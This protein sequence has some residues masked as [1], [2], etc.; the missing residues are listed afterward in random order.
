MKPWTTKGRNAQFGSSVFRS[1]QSTPGIV[2]VTPPYLNPALLRVGDQVGGAF[3]SGAY[4]WTGGPVTEGSP[5]YTVNGVTKA[6]NYVLL[7]GDIV[8][9]A[10]V[11]LT[12]SGAPSITVYAEPTDVTDFSYTTSDFEYTVPAGTGDST[13]P[14]ISAPTATANGATAIDGT[15]DTTEGNG[16]LWIIAYDSGHSAPA[17]GAAVKAGNDGSGA[18]L[19]S[20]SQA[21]TA[22]GTQNVALTGVSGAASTYK[23]AYAHED[24]Y[25]N[26]SNVSIISGTITL[27]VAP[28][29]SSPTASTVKCTS[30]SIGVTTD[31]STGTLYGILSTSATA[32]TAAQIKAGQNHTG[33]AATW[34]G[35]QSISST[36]AKSFTPTGLTPGSTLYAH[37]THYN[38]MDSNVASASAV[39]TKIITKIGSFFNNTSAQTQGATYSLDLTTPDTTNG[40]I[41]GSLQQDDIIIFNSGWASTSDDNPS[42]AGITSEV[43]DQYANATQQDTNQSVGYLVC[44]ASPPS[45]VTVTGSNNAANGALAIAVAYRYVDPVTPMDVAAQAGVLTASTVVDAGA[46]TPTSVGAKIV[47]A[48]ANSGDTTPVMSGTPSN[49]SL[50]ERRS[51]GGS[52]RGVAFLLADADGTAGVAF[53]PGSSSNSEDTSARSGAWVTLALRPN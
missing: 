10:A 44:S 27:V 1:G 13:A 21:V 9:A 38:G 17:N 47:A 2:V 29:L 50:V 5:T 43:A 53:D 30:A 36:G 12:G 22:S 20:M 40:G 33:A 19:K 48:L 15:V 52:T 39:T 14:T 24:A 45:S 7:A 28:T 34:A 4:S 42:V 51:N 18:A 8:A 23:V 26:M 31:K 25:G 6:S 41:G 37:F 11:G 49:M 3:V 16:T 46:I 35:N 32:P